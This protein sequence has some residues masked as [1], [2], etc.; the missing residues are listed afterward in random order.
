MDEADRAQK[1]EEME[2]E[3]ALTHRNPE[4]KAIGYCYYCAEDLSPGFRFCG[5]ECRDKYD[6]EQRIKK[7]NGG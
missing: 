4:L 5:P 1:L 3:A 7:Q 2:R 6:E